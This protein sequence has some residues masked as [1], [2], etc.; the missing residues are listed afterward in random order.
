[1]QLYPSWP[2][3]D[4]P[5]TT[6]YQSLGN[7]K[8]VCSGYDYA[9]VQGQDCW[10]ANNTPSSDT[11]TS[12][13]SCSDTCPGYPYEFCGNAAQ[14]LYGYLAL[15]SAATG[16]GMPSSVSLFDWFLNQTCVSVQRPTL[17]SASQRSC[18]WRLS[19]AVCCI[20]F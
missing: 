9:V 17:A 5:D 4:G 3:A 20:M 2:R 8:T 10:C 13:S 14:G 19:T 6:I 12:I 11:T 1:V 15:S 18:I 7:C 16:T